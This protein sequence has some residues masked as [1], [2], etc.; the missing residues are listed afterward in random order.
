MSYNSTLLAGSLSKGFPEGLVE[1]FGR[2]RREPI[3]EAHTN[4]G[5]F[6]GLCLGSR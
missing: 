1:M 3:T 6:A 2:E 4:G 5:A